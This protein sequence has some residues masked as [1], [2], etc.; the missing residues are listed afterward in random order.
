MGYNH[1]RYARRV[2]PL[3]LDLVN[4][5]QTGAFRF[6]MSGG[7]NAIFQGMTARGLQIKANGVTTGL[8]QISN[9][10]TLWATPT[11]NTDFVVGPT[12]TGRLKFGTH[13]ATGDAVSDGSIEIKDI[14]GTTRKLMTKA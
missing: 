14:G 5:S 4:P 9:T 11:I 3:I 2:A 8:F 6:D 12:G 10:G 13:T 1:F 7:T